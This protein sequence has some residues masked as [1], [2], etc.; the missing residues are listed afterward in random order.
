MAGP[1]PSLSERP[2][3]ANAPQRILRAAA[4]CIGEVGA[5]RVS[6]QEIAGTA[7][8]SKGLIHY[9]FADK[10]TLLARLVEWLTQGVVARERSAVAGATAQTVIDRLWT[11]LAAELERGDLR[12]LVE[13]AHVR[14]EPV[15]AAVRIA[16]ATR[17]RAAE[18]T[19]HDVFAALEL[20]PRIPVPLL[21]DVVVIFVEG[22]AVDAA[23]NPEKEQ[24]VAFDVFWL[25]M[26]SLVE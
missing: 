12:V 7:R 14:D 23:V 6:L 10:E 17:R 8:V 13:L 9:H 21:A 5:L 1:S 18:A 4:R 24:R 2:E 3:R 22:L 25:S 19:I 26:L 15:R 11:W 20:R 16:A